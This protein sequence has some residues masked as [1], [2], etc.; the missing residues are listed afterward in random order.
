MTSTQVEPRLDH[1]AIVASDNTDMAGAT[2]YLE[3]LR[4][5][6]NG[7]QT[8]AVLTSALSIHHGHE[9]ALRKKKKP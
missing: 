6:A 9:I 1:L 4:N 8:T 3:Y 7:Y 5:P 2:G